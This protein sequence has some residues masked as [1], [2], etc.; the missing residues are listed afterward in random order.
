MI[1]SVS[2]ISNASAVNV[3][4]I[5][6]ILN[7]QLRPSFISIDANPTNGLFSVFEPSVSKHLPYGDP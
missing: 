1:S 7:F 5:L 2:P 3:D 4:A 6:D